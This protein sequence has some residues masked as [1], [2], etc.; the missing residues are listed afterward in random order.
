MLALNQEIATVVNEGDEVNFNVQ[1]SST[2]KSTMEG[3]KIKGSI[4]IKAS[5]KMK[6]LKPVSYHLEITSNDPLMGSD[7]ESIDCKF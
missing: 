2:A 1:L 6:N 3:K 4:S 5:G 7:K